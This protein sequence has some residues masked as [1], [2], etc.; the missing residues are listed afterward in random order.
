VDELC[1]H[2]VISAIVMAGLA[3]VLPRASAVRAREPGNGNGNEAR[4]DDVTMIDIP[5]SPTA[6]TTVERRGQIVLSPRQ[7]RLLAS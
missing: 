7:K 6:K 4:A 5:I 3:T 1:S 2:S